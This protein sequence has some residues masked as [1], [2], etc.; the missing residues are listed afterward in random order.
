MMDTK[1]T[2]EKLFQIVSDAVDIFHKERTWLTRK[3]R[4]GEIV[5]GLADDVLP[6][7]NQT[8]GPRPWKIVKY[9]AVIAT[10]IIKEAR[11]EIR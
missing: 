4:A 6:K 11:K 3:L 7:L 5:A 8:R 9:V 1:E 10:Y 2:A